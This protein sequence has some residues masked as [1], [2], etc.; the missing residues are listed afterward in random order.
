MNRSIISNIGLPVGKGA[1]F[2]TM[3]SSNSG[4]DTA[5]LVVNLSQSGRTTSTQ[6]YV[7]RLR[8]LLA[9]RFPREAFL[10]TSGSIV[11][12]ALNEG[13]THADQNPGLGGIARP[14]P[15]YGR[16]DCRLRSPDSGHRRRADRPG[17]RL[18]ATRHPGRPHQ[19][20]YMGLSQ[21]DVAQAILTAYGSSV[22]FSS[23]IWV[24]PEDRHRL[25]HGRAIRDNEAN[26]LD[27][28]RNLPLSIST[29][30][31][32]GD[33]AAVE[34]RHGPSRQHPRR[35]GPLQHRTRQRRV[36]QRLRARCRLGGGG[37]GPA[38]GRLEL[39]PA[40]PPRFAA[41]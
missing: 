28:I 8:P 19:G 27:E 38:T 36:R 39:P 37:C 22:G 24:D 20:P 1:G 10:F 13:V 2:S 15:R 5:F 25:L 33:R 17:A 18:P 6:E 7:E 12:A 4:P 34:R 23:T 3:L 26:S 40:S 31:R 9:E 16:R 14:V 41:R 35:G 29:A 21:E 32:P 30:R 11:N